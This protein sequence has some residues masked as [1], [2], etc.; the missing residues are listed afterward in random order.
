MSH[1]SLPWMRLHYDRLFSSATWTN[2]D[3]SGK[4]VYLKLLVEAFKHPGPLPDDEKELRI[5]AGTTTKKWAKAWPVI[6]RKFTKVPGGLVNQF[7]EAEKANAKEVS[8][9]RKKAASKRWCD[10]N[11]MH[12]NANAMHVN[13]SAMQNDAS[14]SKSKDIGTGAPEAAHQRA[15]GGARSR[16]AKAGRVHA[17]S[18]SRG[19]G[20]PLTKEAQTFLDF[21]RNNTRPDLGTCNP[22]GYLEAWRVAKKKCTPRQLCMQVMAWKNSFEWRKENGKFMPG[23]IKFLENPRYRDTPPSEQTTTGRPEDVTAFDRLS[24]EEQAF[25]RSIPAPKRK[26]EIDA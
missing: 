15:P 21:Y 4:V 6:R 17:A 19:K 3:D 25:V 23:I 2:L 18:N 24:P 14:K 22:W 9:K 20:G 1:K 5:M 12:V 11:A 16:P 10:A 13:A 26:D 8:E 7:I